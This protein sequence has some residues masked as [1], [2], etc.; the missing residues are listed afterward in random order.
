M[1][2]IQESEIDLQFTSKLQS[3]PKYQR[4]IAWLNANGAIYD[5]VI[6]K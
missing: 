1:E 6:K 5:K 2:K 3:D 4:Y